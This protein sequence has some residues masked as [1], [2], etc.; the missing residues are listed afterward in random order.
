MKKSNGQLIMKHIILF[1]LVCLINFMGLAQ[2]KN[3]TPVSTTAQ[4]DTL[5][6]KWIITPEKDSY[7]CIENKVIKREGEKWTEYLD[8]KTKFGEWVT[9]PKKNFA[10][11]NQ[12]NLYFAE[13]KDSAF[14]YRLWKYREGNWS[15]INPELGTVNLYSFCKDKESG[16]I[17]IAK[18]EEDKTWDGYKTLLWK[19]DNQK[20]ER[21]DFPFPNPIKPDKY[22]DECKPNLLNDNSGNIYLVVNGNMNKQFNAVY[23]Y[24]NNTWSKIDLPFLAYSNII[25]VNASGDGLIFHVFDT[26]DTYYFFSNSKVFEIPCNFPNSDF[27]VAANKNEYWFIG[28]LDSRQ[29]LRKWDG[30]GKWENKIQEIS[31][32]AETNLSFEKIWFDGNGILYVQTKGKSSSPGMDGYET[33]DNLVYMRDPKAITLV[34]RKIILTKE[35]SNTI[36]FEI[37]EKYLNE[38]KQIDNEFKLNFGKLKDID[39]STYNLSSYKQ[40]VS[41]PLGKNISDYFKINTK[42]ADEMN[43]FHPDTVNSLKDRFIEYLKTQR[44]YLIATEQLRKIFEGSWDNKTLLH[45]LDEHDK[46]TQEYQSLINKLNALLDEYYK[47]QKI[48]NKQLLINTVL[49][50]KKLS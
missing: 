10:Y 14:K 22:Y 34:K 27:K 33:I 45:F 24:N 42:Y 38:Y 5:F 15:I 19:S 21:L 13:L 41:Q 3:S 32:D 43:S 7:K 2:K 35:Q 44:S 18:F 6:G 37:I 29:A 36:A 39:P 26:K 46:A 28:K 9:V 50:M 30:K 20:I 31:E 1:I 49:K 8:L 16:I 48:S 40:W 47:S 23:S 11:D 25:S 4:Y 12:D 17:F